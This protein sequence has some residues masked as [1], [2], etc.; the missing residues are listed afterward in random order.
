MPPTATLTFTSLLSSQG[1]SCRR[2]DAFT[3]QEP[4]VTALPS[5]ARAV[6][7]SRKQGLRLRREATPSRMESEPSDT[8]A[9]T[10]SRTLHCSSVGA[11]VSCTSGPSCWCT[12][13]TSTHT[14][15]TQAAA[16]A[17]C[18]RACSS[19]SQRRLRR[20]RRVLKRRKAMVAARTAR[21]SSRA[22]ALGLRKRRKGNRQRAARQQRQAGYE[23]RSSVA[24]RRANCSTPAL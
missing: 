11:S 23:R 16:L 2:R 6:V 20:L 19:A 15:F 9:S 14:S 12:S 8:V 7:V 13:A 3:K 1:R 24:K 17:H 4:P 5:P 10:T 22:A 21:R 18:S